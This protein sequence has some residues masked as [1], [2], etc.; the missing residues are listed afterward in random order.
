MTARPAREGWEER[1]A[2]DYETSPNECAFVQAVALRAGSAR[3]VFIIDGTGPTVEKRAAR[4]SLIYCSLRPKGYER[5][6]FGA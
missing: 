6:S 2:F 1:Q 5:E 3:T 4:L